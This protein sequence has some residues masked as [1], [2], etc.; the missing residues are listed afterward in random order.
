MTQET[1]AT[2]S[3]YAVLSFIIGI[4]FLVSGFLWNAIAEGKKARIET[5]IQV[6]SRL[7]KLETNYIYIMEGIAEL[8]RGQEKAVKEQKEA[9]DLLQKHE[10]NS[11]KK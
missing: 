11:V 3:L 4:G 6:E 8:K 10:R 7:V 2:F 1:K 5:N 9:F